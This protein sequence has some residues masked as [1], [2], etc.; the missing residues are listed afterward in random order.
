KAR[1]GDAETRRP[2]AENCER[3]EREKEREFWFMVLGS[4]GPDFFDGLAQHPALVFGVEEFHFVAHYGE[5]ALVGCPR[6]VFHY[7]PVGGPHQTLGSESGVKPLH[8]LLRVRPRVG[9]LRER[10]RV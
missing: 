3:K 5:G 10:P 2:G 7:W 6:C 8:V 4:E 1:R 9:L